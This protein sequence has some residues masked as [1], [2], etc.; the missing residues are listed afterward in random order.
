MSRA[1]AMCFLP[2]MFTA[3]SDP[4]TGGPVLRYGAVVM[5]E[6]GALDTLKLYSLP[7]LTSVSPAPLKPGAQEKIWL[8]VP[9]DSSGYRVRIVSFG[10][11]G[12][13]SEPSNMLD[14]AAG[15]SPFGATYWDYPFYDSFSKSFAHS[16]FKVDSLWAT[17]FLFQLAPET[18]KPNP[19]G[20]DYTIPPPHIR[21][22]GR[23]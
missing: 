3:P 20:A 6:A 17:K 2:L 23:P 8:L 14:Y 5:N 16:T 15:L 4:T 22:T 13:I 18:W 21:I 19:Y 9:G 10:H 11:T 7:S 12:A 1:L